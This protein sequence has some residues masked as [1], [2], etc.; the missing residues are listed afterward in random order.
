MTGDH[1]VRIWPDGT[2]TD[3]P[4]ICEDDTPEDNCDEHKNCGSEEEEDRLV[5]ATPE[6]LRYLAAKYPHKVVI[7]IERGAFQLLNCEGEVNAHVPVSEALLREL[8][9][10]MP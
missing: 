9:T 3:E 7:N 4:H 2:T 8:A 6:G 1:L 10:Q 5:S